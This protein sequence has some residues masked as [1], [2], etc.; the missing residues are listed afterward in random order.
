VLQRVERLVQVDLPLQGYHDALGFILQHWT[1]VAHEQ[2]EM[3]HDKQ[4][5]LHNRLLR[6]GIRAQGT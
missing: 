6:R 2:V 5:E 1:L 4:D 3:P